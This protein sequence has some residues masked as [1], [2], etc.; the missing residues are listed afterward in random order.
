MVFIFF[1]FTLP[2]SSRKEISCERLLSWT[3]AYVLITLID[4]INGLNF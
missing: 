3:L 1:T 4:G 2:L